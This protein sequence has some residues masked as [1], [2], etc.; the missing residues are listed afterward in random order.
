M[1]RSAVVSLAVFCAI[2]PAAYAA[3]TAPRPIVSVSAPSD[4]NPNSC[5]LLAREILRQ[6]IL[7]A[8][9]DELGSNTRDV[10]LREN[11][12]ANAITFDLSCSVDRS[13]GFS[14]SLNRSGS[15]TPPLSGVAGK[16]GIVLL[17]RQDVDIL[18]EADK[19]ETLSRTSFMDTLR[20]AGVPNHVMAEG[21]PVLPTNAPTNDMSIFAGFDAVRRAQAAIR[22]GGETPPRL[23]SLII[24]YANLGLSSRLCFYAATQV[25]EARAL[26][27][28]QR[29]MNLDHGSPLALR[30]RAYARALCGFPGAALADL[31]SAD[32]TAPNQPAWEAIIRAY[33]LY[34]PDVLLKIG[35]AADDP[36]AALANTLAVQ[37]SL[38]T[39]DSGYV[40]RQMH[41]VENRPADVLRLNE[42]CCAEVAHAELWQRA[43]RG[44]EL[45][46]KLIAQWFPQMDGIAQSTR[47]TA[48]LASMEHVD[49]FN[50]IAVTDAVLTDGKTDTA[51]PSFEVLGQLMRDV[52]FVH[53]CRQLDY[54]ANHANDDPAPEIKTLQPLLQAH[55]Y[56]G[57][58][59]AY[60]SSLSTADKQSIMDHTT[61]KDLPA[62]SQQLIYDEAYRMVGNGDAPFQQ[63][64][65]GRPD[66]TAIDVSLLAGLYQSVHDDI[67]PYLHHIDPHSPIAAA[68]LVKAT[69]RGDEPEDTAW[70]T[71]FAGDPLV[72]QMQ[73][74]R[75]RDMN[76]QIGEIDLLKLAISGAPDQDKYRRLLEISRVRSDYS[77]ARFGLDAYLKSSFDDDGKAQFQV[78][79]ADEL[80]CIKQD[81][82]TAEPYAQGA[83][84]ARLSGADFVLVLCYEGLGEWD[85]ANQIKKDY[86]QS[87]ARHGIDWYE[88]CLYTGHGDLQAAHQWAQSA[89]QQLKAEGN[90]EDAMSLPL[91]DGDT[92]EAIAECKQTFA[93]TRD[94]WKALHLAL[95]YDAAGRTDERDA[96]LAAAAAIPPDARPTYRGRPQ[97]FD[98][99][100][101]YQQVIA[102]HAPLPADTIQHFLAGAFGE[103]GNLCYFLGRIQELHGAVDQAKAL[104]PICLRAYRG[105]TTSMALAAKRLAALGIDIKTLPIGPSPTVTNE[106]DWIH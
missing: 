106:N 89:Y 29:L 39:Y 23:A 58:L 50:Q 34:Q 98:L 93:D 33:C 40:M 10:T 76:D 42:E 96:I 78:S 103:E 4:Q 81:Y 44:P 17:G 74:D 92:E 72:Q 85:K 84:D 73:A 26:L 59:Q 65:S 102:T 37:T 69:K 32:Q 12:P 31:D 57:F 11:I 88:W 38:G 25:F 41:V 8:A 53:A 104:Y 20:A 36:N 51:E 24:A 52:T 13:T 19:C 101:L 90:I 71:T 27:Y 62:W 82:K 86:S 2:L 30:A 61:W 14:Y 97:M 21:T 3:P 75:A 80:C 35:A 79:L 16:A 28:A 70:F 87:A 45:M 100:K 1:I 18:D 83:V 49:I 56:V 60:A 66:P 47:D 63:S 48:A 95:V 94:P 67:P 77:P 5:G 6:A 105:R 64:A 7:I 91:I 68:L 43:D 9:R 54:E 55:P 46:K 22:A 15:H 99:I